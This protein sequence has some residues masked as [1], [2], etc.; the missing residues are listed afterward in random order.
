[1]LAMSVSNNN[2][3]LKSL[4]AK[5]DSA[6]AK[7][8][9]ASEVEVGPY[10]CRAVP[11]AALTVYQKNLNE[12]L[13][14]C[15]QSEDTESLMKHSA[16]LE[17]LR[18]EKTRLEAANSEARNS[19]AAL[20]T[21]MAAI[22]AGKD[23]ERTQLSETIT[24]LEGQR[25]S[26]KESLAAKEKESAE[27]KQSMLAL[28]KSA[29]VDGAE[30]VAA[31]KATVASEV[32]EAHNQLQRVNQ[33][34]L[35]ARR[36]FDSRALYIKELEDKIAGHRSKQ[37]EISEAM[38]M[39]KEAAFVKQLAA[40][41]DIQSG[42]VKTILGRTGLEWLQKVELQSRVDARERAYQLLQA[43]AKGA[44]GPIKDLHQVI[45]ICFD[46][47]KLQSFSVKQ[48]ILPWLRTVE[49]DLRSGKVKAARYY[50]E[51]LERV[52]KQYKNAKAMSEPVALGGQP[53]SKWPSHFKFAWWNPIHVFAWAR[54]KAQAKPKG[55]DGWF[56][57]L[58]KGVFTTTKEA[59]TALSGHALELSDRVLG[60]VKT[61]TPFLPW[62]RQSGQEVFDAE[63]KEES[64]PTYA[65]TLKAGIE[66]VDEPID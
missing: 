60:G 36:N 52:I 15:V 22:K 42:L 46:W 29:N 10:R 17:G 32:Q 34:L 50:R 40:P 41:V 57:R 55:K 1:M 20:K 8:N 28:R 66:L 51:L 45:R 6:F 35:N 44:S 21:E 27:L 59:F 54:A 9:Q 64:N 23:S 37:M 56:S 62:P 30:R 19:I 3:T 53:K 12:A 24:S 18:T 33:E 65:S 58:T 31:A 7:F 38:E 48:A 49:N 2:A 39:A 4:R 63:K 26:L 11:Q 14:L 61:L 25:A 47:L 13:A 5:L 43:T 16:Q